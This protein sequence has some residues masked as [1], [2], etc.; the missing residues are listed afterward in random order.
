MPTTVPTAR[1]RPTTSTTAPT[2]TLP[3]SRRTGVS[4]LEPGTQ[5]WG[6]GGLGASRDVTQGRT[7]VVWAVYMRDLYQDEPMQTSA[8]VH[9]EGVVTAVHID[10]GDGT[11]WD[12]PISRTCDP[13]SAPYPKGNPTYHQAPWHHYGPSGDYRVTVR[14]TTVSCREWETTHTGVD[15]NT[16]EATLTVHRYADRCRP[17]PDCP[18]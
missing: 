12:S 11:S 2:T 16:V 3:D 14:V 5:E 4:P 18:G 13:A 1:P 6:Y 9:D 8:E 17:S 10:F 15:E 7:R